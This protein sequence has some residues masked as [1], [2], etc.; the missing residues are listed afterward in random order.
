MTLEKHTLERV[1]EILYT[2][3]FAFNH[4]Y[5]HPEYEDLMKQSNLQ[6]LEIFTNGAYPVKP[7]G[8]NTPKVT[9]PPAPVG[10]AVIIPVSAGG[11]PVGALKTPAWKFRAG[12]KFP[13]VI[14]FFTP[15]EFRAYVQ[16]VRKNEKYSWSP[17]GIT[18]HHTAVPNPSYDRWKNGWDEQLLTNA[19]NGY[20][21]DRGFSAGPHLFTDQNGIWVL[22]PL[23][24]RGTHAVAFNSTR[25]GIEM[26]LNGD[27]KAQ[28]ESE[29]GRANLRMGQIATAILMKDA[30]IPTDKLNFHRDDPATSKTCPGSYVNYERFLSGVLEI[31]K[32]LG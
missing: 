25:Y 2:Q 17:T 30:G 28:V 31:Y 27:D 1:Q 6:L 20:I 3:N 19:R 7:D 15:S 14:A 23:S 9:T 18:E 32:T 11:I 10:P 16:W 22:N 29:V 21:K 24:I 12:A 8:P 5:G 26:L 4:R 13:A